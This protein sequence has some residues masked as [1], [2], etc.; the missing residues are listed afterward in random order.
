M[1]ALIP[2]PECKTE[3]SDKAFTCPKCGCPVAASPAPGPVADH[4]ISRPVE[5]PLPVI[6][7]SANVA[8]PVDPG[9]FFMLFFAIWVHPRITIRKILGTNRFYGVWALL[10]ISGGAFLTT[11]KETTLLRRMVDASTDVLLLF[12]VTWI[13][14]LMVYSLGIVFGGKCRIKNVF[15]TAMWAY[16]PSLVRNF[17]LAMTFAPGPADYAHK[18]VLIGLIL[19]S[20][21][22]D[23][24]LYSEIFKISI[25]KSVMLN[26]IILAIGFGI[27]LLLGHSAMYCI[28]EYFMK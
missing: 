18:A 28:N 13:I 22:L 11:S 8:R 20:N 26:L 10:L 19:W 27:Y 2:C 24:V 1:L 21:F 5:A 17:L 6:T 9:S 15:I 23:L 25:A 16:P 12:L 14:A 3:I 7:E 4:P